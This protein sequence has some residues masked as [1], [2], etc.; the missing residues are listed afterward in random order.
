MTV[1]VESHVA[2]WVPLVER[3]YCM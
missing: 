1:V 3:F 2:F